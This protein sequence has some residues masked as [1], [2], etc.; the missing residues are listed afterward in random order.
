MDRGH[1]RRLRESL[2]SRGLDPEVW[3]EA[4]VDHVGVEDDPSLVTLAVG[5]DLGRKLEAVAA[6]AS[7]VIEAQDF[8]G[9]PPGAFHRVIAYESFRP[10]RVL[11]GRFCELLGAA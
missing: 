4:Q 6:H 3:P 9:L 7:Q 1:L 5:D 2:V 10:A 11:D 8:M